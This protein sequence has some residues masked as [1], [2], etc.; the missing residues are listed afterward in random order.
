MPMKP[1]IRRPTPLLLRRSYKPGRSLRLKWEPG[2]RFVF[3]SLNR[4]GTKPQ[5]TSV[6]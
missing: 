2:P 4:F 5:L 3:R 6:P 1:A